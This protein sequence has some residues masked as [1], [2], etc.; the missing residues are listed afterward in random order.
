MIET[1]IRYVRITVDPVDSEK[2]RAKLQAGR[3]GQVGKRLWA[4]A[5]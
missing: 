2:E 3:E 4:E 1:T 5:Q